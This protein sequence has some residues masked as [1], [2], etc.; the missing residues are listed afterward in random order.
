MNLKFNSLSS[1]ANAARRF[2][3]G[4]RIRPQRDWFVLVSV[5]LALL[6]ASAGWSYWLFHN[7]SV[8]GTSEAVPGASI[9]VSAFD[10]VRTVFEKR[11]AE[12]AHYL[13]DYRFVDPSK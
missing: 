12:R 5:S 3:Y 4:S 13:T 10:T 11:A 1:I 8:D 6:V 7:A 9:N 2:S